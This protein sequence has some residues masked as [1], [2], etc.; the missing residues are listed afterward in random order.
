MENFIKPDRDSH[1]K[2]LPCGCGSGDVGYVRIAKDMWQV[3]CLR[4][5]HRG[6]KGQIRHDIQVSWNT[7]ERRVAV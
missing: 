1:F 7:M 4:C 3:K 2:L 5:G 6:Q